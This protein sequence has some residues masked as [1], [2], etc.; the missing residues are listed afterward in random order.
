MV[1]KEQENTSK[2]WWLWLIVAVIA[3][4]F[5][6]FGIDLLENSFNSSESSSN[7]S[8]TETYS[9]QNYN[10]N[11]NNT[12]S[13]TREV[14]INSEADFRA[15]INNKT[16]QGTNTDRSF[17]FRN[18]ENT[19]YTGDGNPFGTMKVTNYSSDGVFFTIHSPYNNSSHQF[20]FEIPTNMLYDKEGGEYRMR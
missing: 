9:S 4:G 8:N 11:S 5:S 6:I 14:Q 13:S 3:M 1:Q 18:S 17:K 2:W 12:S 16:F 19:W 7:N 15:Y 20:V 10:S